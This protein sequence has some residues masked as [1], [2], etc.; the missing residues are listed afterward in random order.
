MAAKDNILANCS[1]WGDGMKI[2]IYRYYVLINT[3]DG[4]TSKS[5]ADDRYSK[6]SADPKTL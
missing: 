4:P 6:M 1:L 5:R 3:G 2:G